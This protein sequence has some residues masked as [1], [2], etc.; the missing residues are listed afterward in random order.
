MKNAI[1]VLVMMVIMMVMSGGCGSKEVRPEPVSPP[2]EPPRVEGQEEPEHNS[3]YWLEQ[4]P[5][6]LN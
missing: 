2:Y 1:L 6:E 5:K 3:D 4:L